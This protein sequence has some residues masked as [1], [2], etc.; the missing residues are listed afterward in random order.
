MYIEYWNTRVYSNTLLTSATT[1]KNLLLKP[2][3]HQLLQLNAFSLK[4]KVSLPT[5]PVYCPSTVTELGHSPA[6]QQTLVIA[7]HFQKHC[8]A[9]DT[10]PTSTWSFMSKLT[11]SEMHYEAEIWMPIPWWCF[12]SL[13]DLTPEYRRKKQAYSGVGFGTW[14][15]L[16]HPEEYKW[17]RWIFSTNII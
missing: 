12:L 15:T 14:P 11:A 2:V 5:C 6:P 9:K 4:R 1:K 16:S 3:G 7:F 10:S 13:Q 8:N 17:K